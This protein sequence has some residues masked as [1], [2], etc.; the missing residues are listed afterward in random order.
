MFEKLFGAVMVT[1]DTLAAVAVMP[2]YLGGVVVLVVAVGA[3]AW[4][5]LDLLEVLS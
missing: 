5:V 1:L 3:M 4:P 2:A